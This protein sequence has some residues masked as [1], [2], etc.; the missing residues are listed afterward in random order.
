MGSGWP[1]YVL[2]YHWLKSLSRHRTNALFVDERDV[3]RVSSTLTSD[4]IVTQEITSE[5]EQNNSETEDSNTDDKGTC[6]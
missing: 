6:L 5:T 3:K 1:C 4:I 2:R